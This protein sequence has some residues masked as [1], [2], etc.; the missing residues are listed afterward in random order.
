[1]H[2]LYLFAAIA[3]EI[4]GTTCMK[5]SEGFTRLWPSVGIFVFY[6]SSITCLTLAV[7]VI[8]ISIAYA[9]WSAVGIAIIATIGVVVFHEAI[10]PARAFFLL[11]IIV[12]VVGL[13]LSTPTR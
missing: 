13:Q 12:G 3:F 2:W 6:V 5:L 7:K 10:S 9:I 1:M 11:V 8:D 4:S